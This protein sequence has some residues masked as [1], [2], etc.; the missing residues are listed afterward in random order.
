V[1]RDLRATPVYQEVESFY[2]ACLE[3]G[4]GSPGAPSDPAPSPD[5]V[6]IAFSAR[7]L[8][9]LEGHPLTRVC[10]ADPDGWRQITFGPNEDRGARW[11]PDGETL[12]F[13]SDRRKK[14]SHQ[15]Y[16]LRTA[17]FG[18]AE[19]V[20]D[21]SGTV[22]YH[23]W[24]PDGTRIVLGVAGAGAEQADAM[25]SGT[26]GEEHD[27][28]APTWLPEIR[29]TEP[30]PDERR[31]L[32]LLDVATG[33]V[34]PFGREEL[35]VWE[36]TWCGD[37]A[38][39]A[40]VSEGADEGAWY[41]ARV[42]VLD[43]ATGNERE[44]CT[45][46]VQLSF[47]EGS[48]DGAT[49]AMI[50][51]RCSDRYIAAGEL[52]LL[53][54]LAG[55]VRRVETAGA[56]VCHLRW[57]PDGSLFASA[58][59]GMD[60]VFLDI[61]PATATARELWSTEE[62]SGDFYPAAAP[63]PGGAFVTTLSSS[64][65]APAL[66]RIEGAEE[67]A[68]AAPS[69]AGHDVVRSVF[70]RTERVSWT[71]ADGLEIQGLVHLPAG[72]G[73]FPLLVRVH[74][75]PVWAYQDT[76]QGPFTG[77][78]LRRGYALFSPNPRGS[79]GRG[80]AFADM[81]VGDM[82]GADSQDILSGVDHLV[83]AGIADAARI[84]VFGGSYGGFMSAWLPAIDDRFGAAVSYS[85]VTDWVSQH[86]TSSLAEWDDEFVGADPTDPV[87]FGRFSPVMRMRSLRT[88]TLLTAGA[89]DRATPVGQAIEFWQALRLAGVPTEAVVY[90]EE[91]HGVNTFP[92]LIDFAARTLAWF[93]R[94]LPAAGSPAPASG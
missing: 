28:D 84:G 77:L 35:N 25:G 24:S 42:V 47:L 82:G 88:P 86:F 15:L 83:K 29:T 2:R 78:F 57:G 16:R 90:P 61:D 4:F 17:A 58:I 75:G 41:A 65:R 53:D 20:T 22:E 64:A 56:D 80:R 5:G 18:E 11:S 81:V 60:S 38:I 67:S 9:A 33:T 21:L 27:A 68:I 87:A 46:D 70:D 48:R 8:E 36:A 12:T 19:A 92:A 40:V 51:A 6:R 45:S 66:V 85:P 89:N 3:P 14:G 10:L 94:Y 71:A 79:G 93:D 32:H 52:L 26:V 43:A 39:A 13:V 62:A 63:L 72:D 31:R 1:E 30:S 50:E 73:P 7:Y 76:W 23:A 44:L 74:G 55:E 49:L 34:T 54:P 69:H 59:R 91:G 37:G